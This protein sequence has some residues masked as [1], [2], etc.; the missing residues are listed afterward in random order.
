VTWARKPRTKKP[1][2]ADKA[3]HPKKRAFLA[4][5]GTGITISQAAKA[6]G[7]SR[8]TAHEWRKDPN[9]A[10]R[11][12]EATADGVDALEAC[13]L[14]RATKGVH[15]RVLHQGRPVLVMNTEGE[16]VELYETTY[17]DT[18]LI[19]LLKSRD[20]ERFCDRA[21]TEKIIR[22]W[23]KRDAAK[24]VGSATAADDVLDLL[25]RLADQKKNSAPA[26]P[27]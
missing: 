1:A 27:A 16:L 20:P 6:A 17:S 5:I 18:L 15:K 4:A 2:K 3:E 13:A 9:Y 21:R 11:Y 23:D 22:R 8:T 26:E 25:A 24:G 7:I 10:A 19:Y 14:E 12:R